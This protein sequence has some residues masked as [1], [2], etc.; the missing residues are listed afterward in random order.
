MHKLLIGIE[1]P[2]FRFAMPITR[3]IDL[4]HEL[5]KKKLEYFTT[6]AMLLLNDCYL[7]TP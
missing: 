2:M 7:I 4:F 5:G 1:T 3:H 6:N